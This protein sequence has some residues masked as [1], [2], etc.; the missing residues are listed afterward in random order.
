MKYFKVFNTE[1]EYLEYISSDE[2]I[3]PN[4]STLY[5]STKTWI[6]PWRV[7]HVTG[8]TLSESEII[9]DK[10]ETYKLVATVLPNDA[11]DK[12]VT[13]S[14]DN[15]N[16]ATVDSNGVVSSVASGDAT[17]TVTTTDGGF[18]A[19]CSVSVA[20]THDYSKDYFT[21]KSLADDNE[22]KITRWGKTGNTE[23]YSLDSG[24]TWTQV[25]TGT[26]EITI[27]TINNGETLMIKS[28]ANE[29]ASKWDSHNSLT[30]TKNY[31][32]CG[33]IMSL[34]YG[35]DFRGKTEIKNPTDNN[36]GTFCGL[37]WYTSG[38]SQ[39]ALGSTTLI[40]AENLVLPATT[41]ANICYQS[42]F[43]GCTSLTTAPS[44]PATTLAKSCY[45]SMFQGCT[46]LTTAPSLP[47]TTL[48]LECYHYMFQDCTSLTTAP[49]LPATTLAKSC[50]QSMFQGCTSLTTAPNL[51]ATTLSDNC[52]QAMFFNCSK[53]NYIKC[54]A[55]DISASYCTYE[56]VKGVSSSGT[57]VKT[58]T[59]EDWKTGNSGIPTNWTV[60]NDTYVEVT[61]VSISDSAATVNKGSTYTL[62]ANVLPS[63]ADDQVVSWSTSDGN[64][65][66]VDS[67]GVV[68][69]VG[70]GDATIT[71]TTH[72][73][74]YT[75]TCDISV[76]NHVTSVDLD[77]YQLY[78]SSGG[79]YQLEATVLPSD[80]CDKSVT[81]ASNNTNIATV[82]S[83]GLV[84]GV[85]IGDA[86]VTVTTTDGGYTAQCSV[87]VITASPYTELE[88]IE[89]T[90]DG[91]QY[92]DLDIKLYETLNTWYDIAIKY[93]VS[94]AGQDNKQ[95]TL[96]GCQTTGSPYPGTFIRMNDANAKYTLGRYI[97]GAKKDNYLGENSTDIELPVQTAPNKNVTNLNNSNQTHTWGT[98]LFCT[99]KNQ[100]KTEVD[101]FI[102]AKLYYFKLFLK[103][104]ADS[105]GTLVRD[106]MP[107]KRRSDNKVG[108]LDKVN[109]VFYVS[110]NGAE[111]VGGPEVNS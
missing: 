19:Q 71:V 53:L 5:D 88:Y 109:N 3:A 107:C 48:A 101:R 86:T 67:N 50:Y 97:G 13:W 59:M 61:G 28:E 14:S 103:A 21:I 79:T 38:S 6:L 30:C 94:G 36:H 64:V 32:V 54:L 45:Q 62:T 76:E 90:S 27:A 92:I 57:F 110:P 75:A 105:E 39:T 42:M 15:E 25:P 43:Q 98:S 91:G 70:C 106:M 4:V 81:W 17:V 83:N 35:D 24:T 65:A 49:E 41:L 82:D 102:S 104:S 2:F 26:S 69:S 7:I 46:S 12:S 80:A 20:N 29:W 63:N 66:T 11:T 58:L 84:S 87:N 51:P 72:E 37:F 74:G 47:A 55:V 8:V 111:F 108:L 22:V 95:P 77:V 68:T 100:A 78:L 60:R 31:D 44:L 52:Y 73:K 9:V 56:W 18:T 33:N 96:F 34:I 23:F 85:S 40:S 93:N 16:V 99:F 10:D 89:S 1:N